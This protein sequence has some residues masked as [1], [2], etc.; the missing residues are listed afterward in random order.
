MTIED[1]AKYSS[2]CTNRIS[3]HCGGCGYNPKIWHSS[4]WSLVDITNMKFPCEEFNCRF[5]SHLMLVISC[6]SFFLEPY[7]IIFF[8]RSYMLCSPLAL[9]GV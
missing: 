9:G 1:D 5:E 8:C 2:L 3:G 6:I 4:F 7:F